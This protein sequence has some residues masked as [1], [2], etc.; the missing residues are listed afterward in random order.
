MPLRICM[1]GCG[2]FA[3]LAHG[4]AQRLCAASG[5]NLCLSACCD[6]DAERA[7]AYAREFGFARSYTD[8]GRM[9]AAEKPDAVVAAVPPHLTSEVGLSILEHGIPL[10]LEKPPGLSPVELNRLRD[11]ARKARVD[12]QVAFNRRH[13]PVMQRAVAILGRDRGAPGPVRIEYDMV[14]NERWD[15]DFSTTAIHALDG[16]LSLAGSPFRTASM[17]YTAHRRGA[18]EAFDVALDAEC[19]SGLQVAITIL[20]VSG[21][22]LEAARVHGIGQCLSLRLPFA[23]QGPSE[24]RLEHWRRGELVETFTDSDLDF[25]ERIGVYGETS[26]FFDAIRHGRAFT[27]GLD[28]CLQQVFLMEALRERRAGG[29]DLEVPSHAKP[30]PAPDTPAAHS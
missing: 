24:G 2:S 27:P 6:V 13:M 16:A 10:L 22:N 25:C 28:E 3:V 17:R 20:P 12:V 18:Q 8:L 26:A 7:R 14:R 4:P 15:A 11:A 30:Q 23:S 29:I 9:L 19:E 21:R 5:G 1:I